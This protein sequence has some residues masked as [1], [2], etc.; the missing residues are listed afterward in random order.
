[1]R[2]NE[3]V[4]PEMQQKVKEQAS[5]NREKSVRAMKNLRAKGINVIPS[6]ATNK[7]IPLQ[8]EGRTVQQKFKHEGEVPVSVRPKVKMDN[9]TSTSKKT[10]SSKV[11]RAVD[12]QYDWNTEYRLPSTS[13]ERDRKRR[14]TE[15]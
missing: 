2:N 9:N 3:Y 12:R 6:E 4:T 7:D 10:G 14:T 13:N 5:D 11:T 15:C 1:M 8:A